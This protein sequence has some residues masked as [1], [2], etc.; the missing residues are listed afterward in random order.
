MILSYLIIYAYLKHQDNKI[1]SQSFLLHC[2][3]Q[4]SQCCRFH[5]TPATMF[6]SQ[7]KK[8][9]PYSWD[10]FLSNLSTIKIEYAPPPSRRLADVSQVNWP[11]CW[12]AASR[13]R[14]VKLSGPCLA[15]GALAVFFFSAPCLVWLL[16][17]S[18][19]RSSCVC[20]MVQSGG[21]E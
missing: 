21:N 10:F 19:R 11:C 9:S 20:A 6:Q 8:V 18:A 1:N 15:V 12:Q 13:S 4:N 14:S 2:F 5:C 16:S 7:K 3:T 17:G